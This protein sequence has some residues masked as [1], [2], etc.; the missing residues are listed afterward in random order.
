MSNDFRSSVE[1]NHTPREPSK[2]ASTG[3]ATT[4]NIVDLYRV[5]IYR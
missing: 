3:N 1:R 4:D 5:E 2:P